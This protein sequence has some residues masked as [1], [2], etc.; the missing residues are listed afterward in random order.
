MKGL[1][2][3]FASTTLSAMT[4]LAMV[5]SLAIADAPENG[6]AL[7]PT[8][9]DAHRGPGAMEEQYL[10]IDRDWQSKLEPSHGLQLSQADSQSDAATAFTDIDEAARQSSNPLGGRFW[11]VLNQIDNYFMQGD[12]TD[13]TENLN[14]WSLQPVVPVPLGGDWIWVNRPT[15]PFILNSDRPDRSAVQRRVRANLNA[16]GTP[17]ISGRP[18]N[19]VPFTS[20]SGFG[21]IVYFSLVGKSVATER[22]GGGDMVL[23]GG[24]TT[25]FPTASQDELGSDKYSAGPAA[26]GAFIGQEFILGGLFQHWVDYAD[27]GDTDNDVNFSWFNLFYFL[28]FENGWQVGGTPIITADWDADSDDRW[29]VP[30]GLGVY[31]THFFG[32]M[33]IKLGLEGQY[34][35]I[36]PDIYGQEFNIRFVIAPIIPALF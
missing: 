24:L 33:P 29:T 23:A 18:P 7:G 5:C 35:P 14:V 8:D 17:D 16:G 19:N 20:D 27:A 6:R 34:M 9:A 13:D 10:T 25:Q 3:E 21:D 28:N 31:K 30:I 2:K 11:I 1:A 26:V 12:I 15:F 32:K 36:S 4:L 22:W